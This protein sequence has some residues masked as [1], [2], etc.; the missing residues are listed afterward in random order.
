MATIALLLLGPGLALAHTTA[1]ETRRFDSGL[2]RLE[3]ALIRS[4]ALEARAEMARERAEVIRRTHGLEARRRGLA[5]EPPLEQAPFPRAARAR[6][7]DVFFDGTPVNHLVNNPRTDQVVGSTQSEVSIAALGPLCVAAWN[8]AEHYSGAGPL[9]FGFSADSGNTWT[10]AGEMPIGPNAMRWVSDPV[11]T[12]DERR[13]TFYLAA[14]A[15]TG[16]ARNAIALLRGS[17]T[18]ES[19]VWSKPLLIREV[20]DTFP[21]KPWVVADSSTGNVY[22]GYTTFFRKNGV[23]VDQIEFQRSL[24][25]GDHWSPPRRISSDR[26]QGLVQAARPAVGPLGE[27]Y[28]TWMAVDT[29]LANGGL[30]ALRFLVSADYGA[31]FAP[32]ED[33]AQVFYNF[34][35]G[36]PGF[37]RGYGLM[38]PG[39]AVDRSTG[40][41]RGR[42]YVTW[43]ESLNYY[44]DP[45]GDTTSRAEQEPN[46]RIETSLA[47]NLGE[48]LR[49]KI[50]PVSDLDYFRF[51]ADQGQTVI[52]Y[53][54]SLATQPD[55]V[56]HLLCTSGETELAFSA[57]VFGSTTRVVVFTVP[58]S[59]MYY[60]RL[61]AVGNE[62]G[63]YHMR[64]G[65]ALHGLERGRDH[66]DV[67]VAHRD[68]GSAWSEPVRVNDDLPRFDDWMPEVAVDNAGRP[69]AAWYDWRDRT[70]FSCGGFSTVY[71]ARS[72]DGGDS[73]TSL[74]PVSDQQTDW[75]SVYSRIA[76]NQGDYISMFAHDIGVGIA[77]ADGRNGDPDVFFARRGPEQDPPPPPFHPVVQ[78][79]RIAP[80]PAAGAIQVDLALAGAGH[81]SLEIIDLL[82]RRRAHLDL[83]GWGAG[84]HSV[85]LNADRSLAP[86]VYLARIT[87]GSHAE[88]RKFVVTP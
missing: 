77:W 74:G 34:S 53:L 58:R 22:V 43:N 9:G 37:N 24:D 49:G 61:S 57:P 51:F 47:F 3:V 66:R 17:F 55:M 7:A 38:F 29:S 80:N 14:I 67:F 18:D 36:A 25:G 27:L 20:R 32:Q 11:V 40:P 48:T 39:I 31:T 42:V 69:F 28:F 26:D 76:P 85:R 30:D 62:A 65:V 33:V 83:S 5:Q 82:G 60:V 41:H 13:G 68:R 63:P 56:M 71:L 10:D 45:P 19:F 1:E 54:D 78:L 52:F 84:R 79:E 64:T 87:E 16:R 12:V 23:E 50:D 46:N 81:A 70:P 35:S 6:L 88:A 8:D 21:D 72:D 4:A 2:K 59:D 73:W 86:G 44:D 75:T 15:I